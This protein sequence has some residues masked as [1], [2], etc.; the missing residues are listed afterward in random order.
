M[1]TPHHWAIDGFRQLVFYG[2]SVSDILAQLGVLA[3]YALVLV[4]IGTWGLRR[5]LTRS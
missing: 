1:L 5:S 2:A 3:A 4:G